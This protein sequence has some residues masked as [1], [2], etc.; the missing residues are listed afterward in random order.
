MAALKVLRMPT[1]NLT[2]LLTQSAATRV[3]S[4][5]QERKGDVEAQTEWKQ[6]GRIHSK[7][8]VKANLVG[9]KR[10]LWCACGYSKNQPFCD[11]THLWKRFRLKIKQHPVFF[12]APK[13]M[14]A[15]L[16][17]CKQTNKPPYCDGTH[18]RKEVQEAVIEE[19]K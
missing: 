17:L 16:C 8:S 7:K 1:F 18:R 4:N 19:P 3:P 13:D 6:K 2:R 9:G 12:K 10:Y 5:T 15:S 14:T 11:G